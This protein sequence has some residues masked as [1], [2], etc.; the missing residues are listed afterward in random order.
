MEVEEIFIKL[1]VEYDSFTWGDDKIKGGIDEY[2]R[3]C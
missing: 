3:G 1:L 2:F